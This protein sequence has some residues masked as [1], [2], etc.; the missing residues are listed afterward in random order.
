MTITN[1]PDITS[2]EAQVTWDISG[3]NPVISLVN[4]STGLHLSNMLWWFAAYSP[5]NTIIHLGDA[6]N[7][8][9][10]GAW[11][12]Y[13]L[14]DSWPKPFK[15]IEWSGAP[16]TITIYAKDTNGN[17]YSISKS[18]SICRPSGN[19]PTS[20][21]AYGSANIYVKLFCEQGRI[22]FEDQTNTSYKGIT[23][24]RTSATLK[25]AYP[26]DD[27]GTSP[28]PF[29]LANFSNVMVP[30]TYS[31]TNY[32]FVANLIYD[33]DLNNYS[34]VRIKYTQA[35][36]FPVLCNIDL[37]PLACEIV[38][39]ID[40]V[41]N[42]TCGDATEASRKL[43][44]INSKFALVVM[45]K[46]EPLCGVGVPKLIEEIQ[47]IGGFTCDCCNTPTGIISDGSAVIDG[48]T[49]DIVH[50]GGDV[51]GT[52]LQTGT[53]IQF[54][55]HDKSY[56][57][58]MYPGS[59]MDTTAFTI[60]NVT[61]GDGYTKTYY[62]NVNLIQ[63]LT[64]SA[65][66]I[67]GNAGLLNLWQ[68]IFGGNQ[69]FNLTVDG[70]NIFQSTS[71]CNY[72]FVLNGIP[73]DTTYAL[74]NTIRI[75]GVSHQLS[76]SFNLTT[77]TGLQTY[78]NSLGFGTFAVTVPFPNPANAV[79]IASTANANNIES[80][81]FKIS[82]TTYIADM[83]RVCTGYVAISADE[84]VQNII[85]YVSNLNDTQL[86][87]SRDYTISYIAPDGTLQA[88]IVDTG[89]SLLDLIQE[90]VA[91]GNTSIT[92]LQ[93]NSGKVTCDAIQEIFTANV[94]APT[95]TDYLFGTKGNGA[96]SRLGYLEAFNYMLDSGLLNATTKEKFCAMV[97]NCGAGL[98]CLP[99]DYLQPFVTD[100]D[101]SCSQIIGIEYTLS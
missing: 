77:L 45:G 94:A 56:I 30:I 96:C 3:N 58:A 44:L 14:T 32:Q 31:S 25:M 10:T 22:Y 64:D 28:S 37:C 73:A 20:K 75:S 21:N 18:A 51:A 69:N 34:H 19:T 36:T 101:S 42:G 74:L 89:S 100:F 17:V 87:T 67:L 65:Y 5:T 41:E 98:P 46:L 91:N 27:T 95:S 43:S 4:L 76:N 85:T 38:K 52:V 62:L 16:Y 24:I 8:D 1:S 72:N 88:Q 50:V 7:I 29:E 90:L 55:L 61:S 63:F 9:I 49:F 39:L 79:Y 82:G 26:L 11:S 47:E 81:T 53:N 48:Y 84:V 15:Q 59:P 92:Y 33:Y 57:F 66:A 70:E 13:V 93:D 54:L 86:R 6:N 40:S 60:S 83:T 12:T 97:T 78:L 99:F 23:G 2:L 71:T 68:S 35:A 80:L